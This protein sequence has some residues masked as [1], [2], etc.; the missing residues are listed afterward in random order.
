MVEVGLALQGGGSHGAFT[1]GVLDRL[2]D[3]VESGALRISGIS[4]ASAGA[5]N[6]ALYAAGLAQG[7]PKA[8]RAKL[9]AFWEGV[10][11]R[12]SAAGNALFGFADPGLFGFDIDW[13]PGAILLEAAGLVVSPY[14]NPFYYDYLAPL[15]GELFGAP[16]RAAL[17]AP[18]APRVFVSTTNVR[19]GELT[20]F[21]QPNVTA[22]ALRASACLPT[23]FKAVKVGGEFYW[24]G[25]YIAN[26]ALDPLLGVADDLLLV[27][28]NAFL[29]P[30]PPPTTAR[31]I[32]DRL[33]QVTFNASLLLE[34]NAIE[35]VNAVLR[36]HGAPTSGQYRPIRFHKIQN[37]RFA[38]TLGF[39]SKSSTSWALIGTL[40]EKGREAAGAWVGAHLGQVGRES[41][42]DPKA[43]LTHRVVKG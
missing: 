5:I 2:L 38:E 4:G 9:R 41:S 20:I 24:D 22:D 19:T 30:N 7:G 35:A 11:R 34:V 25:G 43:E 13:S 10:S 32:L 36:A 39:V 23:E 18:E 21:S 6:G 27:L 26:P 29:Y 40:F 14:T 31:Q 1:W 16:E 3:E 12:G 42:F 15:I 8:A 28:V 33:N 37:E 17:N